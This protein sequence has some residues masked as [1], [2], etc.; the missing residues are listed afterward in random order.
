MHV[1]D[2]Y[3]TGL[4]RVKADGLVTLNPFGDA[5]TRYRKNGHNLNQW[6]KKR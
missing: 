6:A 1:A 5:L 4:S 3:A 2:N